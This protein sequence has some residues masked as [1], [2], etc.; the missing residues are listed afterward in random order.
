MEAEN[1]LR[2]GSEGAKITGTYVPPCPIQIVQFDQSDPAY[3]A[4]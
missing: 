4:W 1:W 2:L 3:Q